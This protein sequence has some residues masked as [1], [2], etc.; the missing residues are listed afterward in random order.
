MSSSNVSTQRFRVVIAGGGVAALE[1][2]LA[3]R[4]LAG[5]RVTCSKRPPTA[6]WSGPC[7]AP[8]LARGT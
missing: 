2:A 8:P 6:S 5:E 4:D 7:A 1:A 3:L